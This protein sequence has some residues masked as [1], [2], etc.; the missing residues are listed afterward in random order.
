MSRPRFRRML[1]LVVISGGAALGVAGC[2][3]SGAA[4]APAVSTAT[5][6]DV[7]R[8]IKHVVFIVQENRSFDNVFHGFPGAD[9]AQT[10]V[11]HDGTTV[12]LQ[13]QSFVNGTDFG[14]FHTSFDAAYDG[15]LMD[16]FD[17]EGQY[18][19]VNNQYV[20]TNPSSPGTYTY[21]PQ[22]EVQPYW[23]LAQTYT[24]ADRM[25]Q[26]NSGPSFPAHQYLIAG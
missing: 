19:I 26:S 22:A 23:D 14:H 11:M 2:G 21:L 12:T 1:R 3:G 20:E 25:F 6:A 15:G 7:G 17:L 16:G 9:T 4:L 24:V 10:G 8:Y 18:G 13:P 5:T